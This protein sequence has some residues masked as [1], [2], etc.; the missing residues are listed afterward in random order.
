LKLALGEM[1]EALLLASLRAVPARAL[2]A[3]FAFK[4]PTITEAL[5]EIFGREEQ[6]EKSN[7]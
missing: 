6:A 4:Y 2:A 3:G 7:P 5:G 1:A